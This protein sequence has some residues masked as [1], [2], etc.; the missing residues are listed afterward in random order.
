MLPRLDE[1]RL[2]LE[3]EGQAADWA[4]LAPIIHVLG[5]HSVLSELKRLG[6]RER[7]RERKTKRKRG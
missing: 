7:E 3:K 5:K 2:E 4:Q 1:A 6:G